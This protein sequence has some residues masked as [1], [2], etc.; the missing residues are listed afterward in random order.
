MVKPAVVIHGADRLVD[1]G[2]GEGNLIRVRAS[3]GLDGE[4]MV[5]VDV[6]LG[7]HSVFGAGTTCD[8]G[9]VAQVVRARS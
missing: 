2:T 4:Q 6:W 1:G 8:D 3:T 9:R 7:F 5:S